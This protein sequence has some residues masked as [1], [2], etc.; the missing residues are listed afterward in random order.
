MAKAKAK[1]KATPKAAKLAKELGVD[2]TRVKGSGTGGRIVVSD[3]RAAAKDLDAERWQAAGAT[4]WSVFGNADKR[5]AL[6]EIPLDAVAA[7]VGDPEELA[8]NSVVTAVE[9][10]L[11]AIAERAPDLTETAEAAAALELAKQLDHP[12]NSAHS[13]SLCA[14]ALIDALEQ[15]RARAPEAP[16]GDRLDDLSAKRAAR[17]AGLAGA[18]DPSPA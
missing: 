2:L 13:K 1:A 16:K 12:Y 7:L 18:A 3:V 8:G 6:V 10:D 5:R 9:R 17:R 4:V 14:R 11:E 15:L